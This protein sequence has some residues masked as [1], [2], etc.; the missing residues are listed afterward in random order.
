[1]P[2]NLVCRARIEQVVVGECEWAVVVVDAV[3]ALKGVVGGGKRGP[4]FS[5]SRFLCLTRGICGVGF[6][7]HFPSSGPPAGI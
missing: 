4:L 3:R 5:S 2:F 7:I 1:M 6:C